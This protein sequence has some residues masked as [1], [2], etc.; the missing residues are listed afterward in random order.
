LGCRALA[1]TDEE[2]VQICQ[3]SEIHAVPKQGREPSGQSAKSIAGDAPPKGQGNKFEEPLGQ[4]PSRV[5][6]HPEN[7]PHIPMETEVVLTPLQIEGHHPISRYQ[8]C[9]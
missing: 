5:H 9:R 3:H 1:L 7:R 6:S 8:N 2:V 4:A